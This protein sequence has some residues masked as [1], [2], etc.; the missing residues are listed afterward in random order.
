MGRRV[1][2]V[3]RPVIRPVAAGK[4]KS[5]YDFPRSNRDLRSRTGFDWTHL[6]RWGGARYGADSGNVPDLIGSEDAVYTAGDI[7][8]NT[9]FEP[10]DVL[11]FSQILSGDG[12]FTIGTVGSLAEFVDGFGS[13]ALVGH[14]NILSAPGATRY[15]ASTDDGASGWQIFFNGTA[16]MAPTIDHEGA[17]STLLF[18]GPGLVHTGEFL[19]CLKWDDS[20]NEAQFATSIGADETG[21]PSDSTGTLALR[22]GDLAATGNGMPSRWAWCAYAETS[23]LDSFTAPELVEALWGPVP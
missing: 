17:G 18:T 2:T 9:R 5:I 23:D 20:T 13:W 22:F 6:W 15:I 11:G 12:H 7:T 10:H 1:L 3:R 19:W 8:R 14:I 4:S 16:R 21:S